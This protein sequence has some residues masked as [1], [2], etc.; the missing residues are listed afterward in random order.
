MNEQLKKIF[1]I[2]FALAI[3][4]G[5]IFLAWE[6]GLQKEGTAP[7]KP[8]INNAEWKDSLLTVPRSP[9]IK[10]SALSQEELQALA[11]TTTAILSREMLLK[12]GAFMQNR[13]TTTLSDTEAGDIAKMLVEKIDL[14]QATV[15][16]SRDLRIQNDNSTT[17]FATYAQ[18]VGDVMQAF[19]KAHTA[20]EMT[21]VTNALTTKN[22]EDLEGLVKTIAQYKNLQKSLLLIPTPSEIAPLHLRLVQG[23]S[24]IT[25]A[26]IGM[27]NI[28][29]DPILG[30]ASISQYKKEIDAL[31]ALTI[32]YRDYNLTH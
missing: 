6:G 26:I 8:A 3:G 19:V 27:Q 4:L 9:A 31:N 21:L 7:F 10:M 14:P 16:S 12:Y 18:K 23:Y 30:L 1:S 2:A 24:N 22:T 15:Y 29:K 32:D 11:T 5:I 25:A 13:A 20:H 28:V 17:S